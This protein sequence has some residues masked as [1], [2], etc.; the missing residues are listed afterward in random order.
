[1][2]LAP[3]PHRIAARRQETGDV[4][5]L[6]LEPEGPGLPA[7]APGQFA[8]L[9]AFGAGEVPISISAGL[10]RP[11]PLHHTVRAAGTVT[12]A[13]C[14]LR[15]GA[16]VGVRGPYGRAWPVA[17]AEGR[18]VVIV[19]G[20]IGLA[21][22][23]PVIHHVLAHR[24]RFG[25]LALAYG[26]R[27]P[28]DL[29]FRDELA[30]WRAR[31]DIDVAVTVDRAT[32]AWRGRVGVVTTVLPPPAVDPA[33]AVAFLCGPEVMMRFAAAAL[34]DAGLP[35]TAIHVSLERNMVCAVGH[36]GHCQLRELFVCKD[37]PVFCHDEVAALLRRREL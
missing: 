28:A 8:M 10:E 36:C 32:P 19:A 18:D 14:D 35:G 29:L 17:E 11:A 37:G 15:E 27:S 5:T 34:R 26:S 33:G 12:S 22:L 30:A 24:E 3:L 2:T 25:R 20:G 1:M 31:P 13:L 6:A 21:P 9:H 16:Y 7:F 4:W 23:R